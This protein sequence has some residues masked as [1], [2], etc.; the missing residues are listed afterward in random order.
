[1]SQSQQ[2]RVI[3]RILLLGIISA[4]IALLLAFLALG[5]YEIQKIKQET[6]NKLESQTDMLIYGVAPAQ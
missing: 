2:D 3:K 5:F 6:V 4:V 1:M